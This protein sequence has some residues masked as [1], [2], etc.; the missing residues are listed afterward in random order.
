VMLCQGRPAVFVSQIN[1]PTQTNNWTGVA[2]A[3]TT[4]KG[5]H[6]GNRLSI[7]GAVTVSSAIIKVTLVTQTGLLIGNLKWNNTL[8]AKLQY[9][10]GTV[11]LNSSQTLNLLRDKVGI[12]VYTTA[13]PTGA[14]GGLFY[15]SP[16]SFI[17]ALSNVNVVGASA[18]ST[19]TNIGLGL[20]NIYPTATTFPTDI[21]Q[22]DTL[23]LN[24]LVSEGLIVSDVI[25]A[26]TATL[27][28]ASINQVGNTLNTFTNAPLYS[29]KLNNGSVTLNIISLLYSG[30]G[31]LQINSVPY[32]SGDVRGQLYPLVAPRRRVVPATFTP[33]TGALTGSLSALYR[34]TQYSSNNNRN[35]YVNL[36]PNNGSF[37]GYF[38]FQLPFN[39]ANLEDVRMFTLDIN[40]RVTDGATW[41]IYYYNYFSL[42]YELYGTFSSKT[43][44][45]AFLDNYDYVT[46]NY[47]SA[48]GFMRIRLTA[49]AATVPMNLD[50]F[51]I[52]PWTPNADAN[53]Y[54]RSIIRNLK[55]SLGF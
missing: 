15:L 41:T 10:Y 44:Q 37:D 40:A 42:A 46:F 38:L 21:V 6:Y 36:I 29:Y 16:Y 28:N 53:I 52:R 5:A 34:A 1:D 43:W 20:V 12:L 55:V 25:N 24:T 30:Q 18:N 32:P 49:T 13:F 31:Y 14:I 47:I 9:V 4:H 22:A 39:K 11:Q 2:V 33:T 8:S 23:F 35:S 45:L 50:E 17:A 54:L 27:S 7:F 48:N 26:T 3:F 19:D 51:T